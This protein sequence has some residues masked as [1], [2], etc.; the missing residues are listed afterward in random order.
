[1]C[2]GSLV[3]VSAHI[4]LIYPKPRNAIDSLLAEWSGEKSPYVWEAYGD[5]PC[6]CTNGS[7]VCESAQTC[8]WFS[9]GCSIGCKECDGGDKGPANP[10]ITDRCGSG[11][12][13][14]VNY[15]LQRTINRH[16]VA[17]SDEEWTKFNPWRAA[18]SAPVYDPCGQWR[19]MLQGVM[20]SSQT[21]SM[22]NSAIWVQI[23]PRCPP[24]LFGR[25]DC[26]NKVEHSRQP[27]GWLPIS[28]LPVELQYD[29]GVLPTD[30][31]A[32]CRRFEHD[33]G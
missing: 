27:R 7:D 11:M 19:H 25:L 3:A 32:V 10:N 9:A 16:A 24:A 15:P 6:G 29:G 23:C 14:T 28:T 2:W 5:P 17:G 22:P 18:G 20:A 33:A 31:D 1:M 4:N 30:T 13:A 21:Q 12:N 8:L 26:G